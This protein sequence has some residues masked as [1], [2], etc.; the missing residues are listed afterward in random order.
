MGVREWRLV[1]ARPPAGRGHA[2]AH[3]NS[4]SDSYSDAESYSVTDAH[5]AAE[6]LRGQSARQWVGVRERGLDTA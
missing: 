1:A 5:S 3:T 2:D 4:D 6:H